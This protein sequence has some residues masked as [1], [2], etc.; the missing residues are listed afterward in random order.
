MSALVISLAR[1]ARFALKPVFHAQNSLIK[2]IFSFIIYD[3]T[4]KALFGQNMLISLY[5]SSMPIV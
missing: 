1:F 5:T 4:N 2:F 3:V